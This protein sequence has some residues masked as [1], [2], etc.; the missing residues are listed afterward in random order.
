MS[1]AVDRSARL[2][3]RLI[4]ESQVTGRQ[5]VDGR[6]S[7]QSGN[8][9]VSIPAPPSNVVRTSSVINE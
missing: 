8:Q 2:L 9:Q 5:D 3:L 1:S 7:F 6:A 4:G